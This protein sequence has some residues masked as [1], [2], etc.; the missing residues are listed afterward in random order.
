MWPALFAAS[1]V[2]SA[3]PGGPDRAPE[4]LTFEVLNPAAA[5]HHPILHLDELLGLSESTAAAGPTRPGDGASTRAPAAPAASGGRVPGLPD[6]KVILLFTTMLD[7]CRASAGLCAD[8]AELSRSAAP[9][10]GVVIGVLLD[11]AENVPRAR[12]EIPS[13]RHPFIITADAHGITRH[14]LALDRPGEIL[15]INSRGSV[16][17]FARS[18]FESARRVFEEALVTDKEEE[19]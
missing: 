7:D 13:A 3:P 12:K 4:W 15:V 11:P 10:G 2:F 16:V 14:A 19:G 18:S 6:A 1:L 17:R 9:R 5:G 8:F